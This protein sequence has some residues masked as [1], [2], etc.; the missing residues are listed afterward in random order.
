MSITSEQLAYWYLRLNGFLT[1]ENFV[2]HPDTGDSQRTDV[3]ILAVRFPHRSEL[4]L[5]ME[6]MEDDERILIDRRSS[7][8]FLTEVKR[9]RCELNGPWVRPDDQNIHRVLAATGVVP[10]QRIKRAAMSLYQSGQYRT[11]QW[12]VSLLCIGA[13]PNEDLRRRLPSVPQITW[14]E[15]LNFIWQRFRRY[16]RQKVSHGQ[17]NSAGHELWELAETA[18]D[19]RSFER[20][21]IGHMM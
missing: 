19:H 5:G 7:L 4:A 10:K 15:S 17:W 6:P 13:E 8:V 16:R 2:V 3:D 21:V 9:R 11:R 18:T 12:C 1:I 14:Q 20:S